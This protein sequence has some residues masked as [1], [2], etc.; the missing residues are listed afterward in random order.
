M[1]KILFIPLG[2]IGD[3]FYATSAIAV[4]KRYYPDIQ[5]YYYSEPRFSFLNELL[6][7][8]GVID[9][10]VH[11]ESEIDNRW[12]NVVQMPVCRTD[13]NPVKTYCKSFMENLPMD[14]DLTPAFIDVSKVPVSPEFKLP[15]TPYVTYQVDWQNRTSLNVEY[16]LAKLAAHGVKCVPVGRKGNESRNLYEPGSPKFIEE[17]N[18]RRIMINEATHL[19]AG[20]TFHLSMNGGTAAIAAYTNTRCGITTDWHYVRHNELRLDQRA[21]M[22]WMKLIPREVGN[23]PKHH[24]F[25]PNITEDQLVEETM[26]ILTGQKLPPNLM[27]YPQMMQYFS[28]NL[29][30]VPP[31]KN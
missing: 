20:A 10:I 11:S 2:F 21:Y 17:E 27:R 29:P 18:S 13:E 31:F 4:V 7:S 6:L 28:T 30:I 23:N 5:A 16:I 25:N 9:G 24:M 8:T 3:R 22:N 26:D 14:A 19:I 12:D 15:T 1:T